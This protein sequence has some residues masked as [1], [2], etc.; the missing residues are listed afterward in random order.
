[1]FDPAILSLPSAVRQRA[2]VKAAIRQAID[3]GTFTY[4]EL[5]SCEEPLRT[6]GLE[7]LDGVGVT[8]NEPNYNQ[9]DI[10]MWG[11]RSF[12]LVHVDPRGTIKHPVMTD[13]RI[14]GTE[15]VKRLKAPKEFGNVADV[16]DIYPDRLAR[17][18][19]FQHG[20]PCRQTITKG[21]TVGTVVE[22]EWLKKEAARPDPAPGV[23]E[24]FEE[25][26]TRPGM[27]D[28]ATLPTQK[29]KAAGAQR[30]LGA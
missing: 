16:S 9:G 10:E 4:T 8:N 24:L 3:R 18:I 14:P 6:F 1:M 5:L 29:S 20:W 13:I 22:W 27:S 7:A 28:A 23:R 12:R 21:N 2:A 15:N 19:L 17:N 11:G 30:S 25:I 26:S